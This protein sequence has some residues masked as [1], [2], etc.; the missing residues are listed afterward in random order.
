MHKCLLPH[1]TYRLK[2][3]IP[4]IPL[5]VFTRQFLILAV[6]Q[7]DTTI[8]SAPCESLKNE[9]AEAS[10]ENTTDTVLCICTVITCLVFALHLSLQGCSQE[11]KPAAWTPPPGC[12]ACGSSLQSLALAK[13]KDLSP[14]EKQIAWYNF[15][16]VKATMQNA[17]SFVTI[18]TNE[19]FT[20]LV[21]IKDLCYTY[22][23]IPELLNIYTGMVGV[24]EK[25]SLLVALLARSHLRC[26]K[27]NS[28]L[29]KVTNS[30]RQNLFLSCIC[31]I[32]SRGFQ[33]FC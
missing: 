29:P 19:K 15:A 32:S 10:T 9:N 7:L 14:Q 3:W 16:S 4:F 13:E 11:D 27:C 6:L 12:P 26:L 21:N 5:W 18:I 28:L 23:H 1:P 30:L 17:K 22:A 33:T 20:A 8:F 24:T 31:T 25:I 2:A